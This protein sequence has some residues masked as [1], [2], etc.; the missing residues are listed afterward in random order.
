MTITDKDINDFAYIIQRIA[1][2]PINNDT[3]EELKRAL[4][5]FLDDNSGV[6]SAAQSAFKGVLDLSKGA[7]T[8]YGN[9]SQT[10]ALVISIGEV[11]EGGWAL[12]PI[13]SNGNAITIPPTWIFWGG[14]PISLISNDRNH[15]QVFYKDANTI[16]WSNKV[17][18]P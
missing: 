13:I 18:T 2:G 7:G 1:S 15:L 14:D 6:P 11:I 4:S 3:R 8:L 17:V 12:V 16:Y 9:Y 5:V 10:G